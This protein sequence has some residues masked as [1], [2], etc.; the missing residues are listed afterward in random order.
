MRV[1]GQ[2]RGPVSG[3]LPL[4]VRAAEG[5]YGSLFFY[6]TLSLEIP[7]TQLHT[8]LPTITPALYARRPFPMPESIPTA[9]SVSQI[10]GHG[11][12][13]MEHVSNG[14][15][16]M[17]TV[18]HVRCIMYGVIMYGVSYTVSIHE[19]KLPRCEPA[20]PYYHSWKQRASSQRGLSLQCVSLR[21]HLAPS[22]IAL[23]ELLALLLISSGPSCRL[24][25]VETQSAAGRLRTSDSVTRLAGPSCRLKRV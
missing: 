12:C 2:C 10:S 14:V 1:W 19:C 22:Q 11:R 23:G 9:V 13:S 16:M 21:S 6:L 7:N 15:M 5:D 24:K 18:Y 25:R 4:P 20:K 8:H 17:C 3:P